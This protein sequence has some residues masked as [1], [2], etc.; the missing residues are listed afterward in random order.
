MGTP[1]FLEINE[2]PFT[3]TSSD[4]V[5]VFAVANTIDIN[6][7]VNVT[8]KTSSGTVIGAFDTAGADPTAYP[9]AAV[10][11]SQKMV[12]PPGWSLNGHVRAM[13]IQASLEDLRGYI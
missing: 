4:F 6:G 7:G 5:Y 8:V 10:L 13:G 3:N 11:R 12:I 1:K 2:D 9:Y